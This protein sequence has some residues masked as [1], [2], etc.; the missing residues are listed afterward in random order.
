MKIG[1]RELMIAGAA[2]LPWIVGAQRVRLAPARLGCI[3]GATSLVPSE[4][5]DLLDWRFPNARFGEL[6]CVVVVPKPLVGRLPLLVALHGRGETVDART[7]AFAFVERYGL[8]EA[9]A[10]LR[11]PGLVPSTFATHARPARLVALD[12]ALAL[13]PLSGVVVACPSVP[14]DLGGAA[15]QDYAKFLA[16]QLL[17]KLRMQVAVASSTRATGI[18]GVSLGGIAALRLGMA[19]PDLFG[20]V[21]A[22]Q[23]AI[24]DDP[25]EGHIREP[26]AQRLGA[27]RMRLMTTD[28]DV[29]RASVVATSEWLRARN[30]AHELLVTPGAHDAAFLANLGCTEMLAWHDVVLRA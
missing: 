14:S 17:P 5:V 27:R 24:I 11:R 29:Y 20:A 28:D 30:V 6:R 2:T 25:P 23:P 12:R 22:M 26:I 18:D 16:D 9:L 13:A 3:G 21:A 1:R 7:G 19:R 10:L 15:Y 4:Q 8:L